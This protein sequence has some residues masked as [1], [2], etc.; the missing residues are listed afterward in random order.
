MGTMAE[1]APKLSRAD[2]FRRAFGSSSPVLRPPWAIPE[3]DFQDICTGCDDCIEACPTSILRKARG[4]YPVVDFSNGECTFCGDCSASCKPKAL[5][6]RDGVKPWGLFAA[7][8]TSC[9]SVSGVTCRVCGEHC[10]AR[11][12]TFKI[13]LGGKS[14]PLVD[15][16]ICTGCGACVA[17]CPVNAVEIE[18]EV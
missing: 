13:E 10:D 12:I 7:I 14:T 8:Q 18:M 1:T 16:S 2:L 6:P 17:P 3:N 4:G 5:S 11:A 9:M 15:K